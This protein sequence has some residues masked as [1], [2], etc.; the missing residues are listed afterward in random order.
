MVAPSSKP[1]HNAPAV[2]AEQARRE[3]ERRRGTP[4][5][6]SKGRAQAITE[7]TFYLTN[8]QLAEIAGGRL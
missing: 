8:K 1:Q 5:Q 7:G 2:T 4:E 6:K 3:L